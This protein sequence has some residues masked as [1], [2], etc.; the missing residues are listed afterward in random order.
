[1]C[2]DSIKRQGRTWHAGGSVTSVP[3]KTARSLRALFVCAKVE[4]F[5]SGQGDHFHCVTVVTISPISPESPRTFW[6]SG[7]IICVF[8]V[9]RFVFSVVSQEGHHF[10]KDAPIA[11]PLFI[12][13]L[14]TYFLL[15]QTSPTS[16]QPGVTIMCGEF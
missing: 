10:S 5:R 15:D 8:R 7:G 3:L 16:V 9:L 12:Y 1:M 13:I 11:Q 4:G 2:L 6:I 14:F